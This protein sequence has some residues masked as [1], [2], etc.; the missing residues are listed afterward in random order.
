MTVKELEISIRELTSTIAALVSKVSGLEV[1]IEAQN[2]IISRLTKV[3]SGQSQHV[4]SPTTS[5]DTPQAP[6]ALQRPA[7]LAR[8]AA[9]KKFSAA[10]KQIAV[11]ASRESISRATA[12]ITPDVSKSCKLPLTSAAATKRASAP[13]APLT[14]QPVAPTSRQDKSQDEAIKTVSSTEIA[15]EPVK[16]SLDN[17]AWTVVARRSAKKRRPHRPVITGTGN[18]NAGLQAVERL[19][20]VQVWTLKPS[21]TEESLLAHLNSI[22]KCDKFTVERRLLKSSDHASFII[23]LPECMLDLVKTPTSWPP[24][25]KLADWFPARPRRQRGEQHSSRNDSE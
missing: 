15:E 2:A 7:S 25:V 10:A 8:P 11:P 14:S 16:T 23:G 21:T 3:N 1:K 22:S 18:E 20:Y 4:N 13:S 19:K 24:R 9:N 12:T 17:Q 5:Q 6:A